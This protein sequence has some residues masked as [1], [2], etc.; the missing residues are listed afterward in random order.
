MRAITSDLM[1]MTDKWA[2]EELGIPE[3][4]LME[5]A[6]KGLAEAVIRSAPATGSVAVVCGPGNNGGD[7]FVAA[8]YLSSA[9][10]SVSVILTSRPVLQNSSSASNLRVLKNLG[11]PILSYGDRSSRNTVKNADIIIDCILGTG[12]SRKVTGILK[13]VI[14]EINNAGRKNSVIV[15]ADIP[16]GMDADTGRALGVC[17]KAGMTVTFHLPKKGMLTGSGMKNCGD[18]VTID[19]GIPYSG[20]GLPPES[21]IAS[22]ELVRNLLPS[23]PRAS[24][25]GLYGKVLVIGGSDSM[26]GA[27]VLSGRAAVKT[28]SGIVHISV[29]EN[30]KMAVNVGNPDLIVHGRLSPEEV[31]AMGFDAVLI[32]PGIGRKEDKYVLSIIRRQKGCPLVIDADALNC[33]SGNL[34]YLRKRS[35][36]VIVTPHP[37]EFA[38]L[39]GRPVK[40]TSKHRVNEALSF[41]KKYNAVCVL[42]GGN[43]VIASPSGRYKLNPTGNNVLSV[44]GTGDILAGA[45]LS[46]AGQGLDPFSASVAGAYLHGA[47]GDMY[48][49]M[50]GSGLL[51]SDLPDLLAYLISA[52]RR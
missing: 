49:G 1:R 19:I 41:A 37:G 3:I 29:P 44:A 7:G 11:I 6:G 24:H 48:S 25:K 43:T 45:I 22:L 36:P 52:F 17:V 34:S 40:Q 50:F 39:T 14:T 42:K 35:A 15:S 23:R 16:S 27:P 12:L 38:R 51:A 31:N 30:A 10:F 18:I 9:G 13:D 33:L 4:V 26:L 5:N 2:I 8:R 21:S 47:A 46:L 20:S 32:G 28:G